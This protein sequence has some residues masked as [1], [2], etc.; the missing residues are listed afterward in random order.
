VSVSITR[1]LSPDEWKKRQINNLKAVG[2]ANYTVGKLMLCRM[3]L[4]G[5]GRRGCSLTYAA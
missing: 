1:I 4:I 3:L 5:I 2:E